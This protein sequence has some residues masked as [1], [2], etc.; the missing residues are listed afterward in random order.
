MPTTVTTTVAAAAGSASTTTGSK[1]RKNAARSL[2]KFREKEAE[3]ARNEWEKQREW[4]RKQAELT[5]EQWH[6]ERERERKYWEEQTRR[7]NR[8]PRRSTFRFR[9]DHYRFDDSRFVGPRLADELPP[10]QPYYR[11]D[12]FYDEGQPAYRHYYVSRYS[13][14]SP[15]YDNRPYYYQDDYRYSR[16]ADTGARIGARIGGTLFGSEGAAIGAGIGSDIGVERR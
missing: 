13:R 12:R 3:R 6:K 1:T 16:G 5:R 15:R 2:R 7:G 14:H 8:E 10:P 9:D 11:D 4:E